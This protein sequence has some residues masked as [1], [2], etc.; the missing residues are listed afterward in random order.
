MSFNP[1]GECVHDVATQIFPVP[2]SAFVE[3]L[4]TA[5]A[6]KHN[7]VE[8]HVAPEGHAWHVCPDGQSALDVHAVPTR[9]GPDELPPVGVSTGVASLVAEGNKLNSATT[10][11]AAVNVFFVAVTS[12]HQLFLDTGFSN[13]LVTFALTDV[14]VSLSPSATLTGVPQRTILSLLRE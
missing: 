13:M 5:G 4:T 10:L 2:H 14:P 1:V 9:V 8:V 7:L 12:A 3:H 6:V 11:G